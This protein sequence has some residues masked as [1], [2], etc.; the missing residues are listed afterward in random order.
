[1]PFVICFGFASDVLDVS[2]ALM[3]DA[4]AEKLRRH[5]RLKVIVH[6]HSQAGA[7]ASYGRAVSQARATRVRMELLKRLSDNLAWSSEAPALG[8]APS[9]VDDAVDIDEVIEHYSQT[10]C[11]GTKLQ[12]QGMW[13]AGDDYEPPGCRREGCQQCTAA[14]WRVGQCAEV[15]VSGLEEDHGW[16]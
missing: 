9:H 1:M 3:L 8:R 7:P 12:A 6:G 2:S 16:M 10:T 11:I 13:D 4:L 14:P 15:R 5:P